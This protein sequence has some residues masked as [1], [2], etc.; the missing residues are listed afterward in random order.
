MVLE[1]TNSISQ[2]L[3]QQYLKIF[4]QKTGVSVTK[5]WLIYVLGKT[6]L[7]DSIKSIKENELL[8]V[9]EKANISQVIKDKIE[10]VDDSYFEW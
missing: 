1:P 7:S 6:E 8:I 2:P 4:G 3:F 9:L 10:P 5:N